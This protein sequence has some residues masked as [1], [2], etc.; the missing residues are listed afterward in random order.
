MITC[1]DKLTVKTRLSLLD[2][3]VLRVRKMLCLVQP[4]TAPKSF[5]VVEPASKSTCWVLSF[6]MNKWFAFEDIW[7]SFGDFEPLWD[8]HPEQ[9]SFPVKI[10]QVRFFWSFLSHE[11]NV[12]HV[13]SCKTR[14]TQC[15]PG[16][17]GSGDQ[18]SRNGR[19]YNFIPEN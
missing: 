14:P 4:S 12:K 6:P 1:G 17:D 16:R 11:V 15:S 10:L 7:K 9:M 3:S 13:A 19:A 2:I 8:Q 5:L 18:Q